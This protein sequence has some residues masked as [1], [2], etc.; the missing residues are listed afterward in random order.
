MPRI[1]T[2]GESQVRGQ[3]PVGQRRAV[4][5]DFGGGAFA[6][7]LGQVVG[8]YANVLAQRQDQAEVSDLNAKMAQASADWSVKLNETLATAQPGDTTIAE[9]FLDEFD[10]YAGKLSE[11]L[12]TNAGQ[13]YLQG[14]VADMRGQLQVQV[15]NGQAKLVGLKAR[16]DYE[17]AIGVSANALINDPTGFDAAMRRQSMALAVAV[18]SGTISP[19]VA[20]DLERSSASA[21]GA[22]AVHG[23]INRDPRE[24][25]AALTAGEWDSVI[26]PDQKLALM[27]H[28]EVEVRRLE[29]E[30][31]QR[32]AEAQAAYLEDFDN[33]VAFL[34][35]GGSLPTNQYS[36]DRLV[37]IF[38]A[39]KG[40]ELADTVEGA[41][42]FGKVVSAVKFAAPQEIAALVANEGGDL[43]SPDDY[44][45]Q[46]AELA[47]LLGAVEDRNKALLADP[48]SFVQS[49]PTVASAYQTMAD[50]TNDPTADADARREATRAYAVA[51]LAE[52]ERLGLARDEQR[53][54][55]PEFA[56]SIASQFKFQPEGGE[57]AAGIVQ[58][59]AD[60]WGRY[61]PQVA[62]EL[63]GKLPGTA[64]VI[65][66]MPAGSAAERLAEAAN[67]GADTLAKTL[68]NDAVKDMRDALPDALAEFRA[69]IVNQPGGESTYATYA[70]QAELLGLK[71]MSEGR[72]PDDAAARAAADVATGRYTFVGTYR[73]PVEQDAAKVE[74]GAAVALGLLDGAG[75]DM[76]RSLF[77]LNDAQ[78]R[79]AWLS[80]VRDQ[81]VWITAPDESGLVL[82][83]P[84]ADGRLVAVTINGKPVLRTWA[85]LMERP[86]KPT[87]P[88]PAFQE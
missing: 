81:G 77:G 1:Q 19:V 63:S 80:T 54:L 73:V 50:V 48:A 56:D 16:Q 60:Q 43:A 40:G 69:T 52:Q 22:A 71:Y 47:T 66:S 74:R 88:V 39:D 62:G 6:G 41:A 36:R 44:K 2:Y 32:Q 29:T 53:L 34:R 61:W 3:G 65:A 27:S 85:E 38:G 58:G 12:N 57:N 8:D 83:V 51:S 84:G 72:S 14:A 23:A 9:K 30:A 18:E 49:A 37:S 25:L 82:H 7:D 31:R 86:A 26:N 45:N 4:A 10:A 46:R 78:T 55:S 59:L 20:A 68:P 5:E 75:I 13:R 24:A 11:G 67:L 64:K 76:P 17:T 87:T 21:L 79:A 35:D 28:A 15:A 33:T 42:A 70:E